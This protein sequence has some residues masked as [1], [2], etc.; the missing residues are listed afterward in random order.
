MI[1]KKLLDEIKNKIA[2]EYYSESAGRDWHDLEVEEKEAL[3]HDVLE[4]YINNLSTIQENIT[5][6]EYFI[7]HAP[8]GVPEWFKPNVPKKPEME[9]PLYLKFGRGSG[10]K[11]E[12]LFMEYWNEEAEGDGFPDSDEIP[13][14]CRDE[15]NKYLEEYIERVKERNEWDANYNI[16]I[17]IQ[18]PIYWADKMLESLSRETK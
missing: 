5:K 6:R 16:Q 10:H 17:L 7:A 8:K 9:T 1:D 2:K 12:D 15:V 11:Y 14:E 4:R 18:W 3:Y 13:Q